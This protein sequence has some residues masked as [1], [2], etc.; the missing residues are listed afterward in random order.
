M[1]FAIW[2]FK[3]QRT[4]LAPPAPLMAHMK[5]Y[6]ALAQTRQPG[7]QNWKCFHADRKHTPRTT[8][9]GFD[10]KFMY[11]SNQIIRAKFI[12]HWFKLWTVFPI[13]RKEFFTQF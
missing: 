12:Q 10:T 1:R 3:A 2:C 9:E 5:D 7:A 11:P 6:S 4:I 13:M 8:Y